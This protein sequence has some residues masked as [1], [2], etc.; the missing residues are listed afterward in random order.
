MVV[1]AHYGVCGRLGPHVSAKGACLFRKHGV[2]MFD[3]S[4]PLYQRASGTAYQHGIPTVLVGVQ[5]SQKSE[6]TSQR[7]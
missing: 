7:L 1:H 6:Q 3:M 2:T 5:A 4:V